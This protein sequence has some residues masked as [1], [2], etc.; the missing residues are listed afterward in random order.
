MLN[1]QWIFYVS[2]FLGLSGTIMVLAGFILARR[3]VEK[4]RD[5]TAESTESVIL[6]FYHVIQMGA[7]FIAVSA[8]IISF[9]YSDKILAWLK[10]FIQR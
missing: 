1:G 9:L 2:I 6:N 4:Q 10:S 8:F 7:I 3:Y 5:K